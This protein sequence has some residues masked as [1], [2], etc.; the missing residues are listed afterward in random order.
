VE[1]GIEQICQQVLDDGNSFRR[2]GY[3]GFSATASLSKTWPSCSIAVSKTV[4][5]MVREGKLHPFNDDRDGELYFNP[6]EIAIIAHI[7]I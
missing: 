4:L 3:L 5:Q 7:P 2:D 6:E 1:P